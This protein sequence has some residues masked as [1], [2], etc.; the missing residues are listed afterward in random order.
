M[1][2]PAAQTELMV[3][4][5]EC[6]F[7]LA[8]VASEQKAEIEITGEAF[9]AF[10]MRKGNLFF[11]KG[12]VEI[13]VRNLRTRTLLLADRQTSAAADIAEQTAAK[14]A[15][16]KAALGLAERVIPKLGRP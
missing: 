1:R 9:S 13:E 3:L 2:D 14:T 16:E 4:L 7:K 11:C 10:G 8:D 5:R 12:R 6:G 15:L